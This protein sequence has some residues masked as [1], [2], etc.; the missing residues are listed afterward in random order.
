MTLSVGL[1]FGTSNSSVAVYD[2]TRL[3]LLPLDPPAPDPAVLRSL[4]YLTRTGDRY[5]GHEAFARHQA[6][7]IGRPVKLEWR[8]VGDVSMTFAEIGTITTEAYAIVDANEPGRL[9]QSIKTRLPDRV[10]TKTSVF[11][12]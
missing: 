12:V 7:N 9:F 1:D 10:F 4:L 11:G 8:P 3:R 2:G 5:V 6:D